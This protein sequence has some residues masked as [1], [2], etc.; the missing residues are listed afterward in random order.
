MEFS[1]RRFIMK[2]QN[3]HRIL[4][5]TL[6]L[7]MLC[8]MLSGL[9]LTAS[10]VEKYTITFSTPTNIGAPSAVEIDAGS[11]LRL[12][13]GIAAPEG[14]TFVGWYET[15]LPN[16][17]SLSDESGIKTGDYTPAGSM[18]LYACYKHAETISGYYE[19]SSAT[20]TAEPTKY[21]VVYEGT[22]K[23]IAFNASFSESGGGFNANGNHIPVSINNDQIAITDETEAAEYTVRR[24][25]LQNGVAICSILL[26]CNTYFGHT[27]SSAGMSVNAASIDNRITFD[28]VGLAEITDSNN[29]YMF[30][31]SENKYDR[32]SYYKITA[33]TKSNVYLY[34]KID[35]R[36][37]YTYTTFA[38]ACLH[39]NKTEVVITPATCTTA[40]TSMVV[41][42]DC[43]AVLISN[44]VLPA[45]GH[46]YGAFTSNNNST[47]S[48]TCSRCSDVVT[49]NCSFTSETVGNTTT[50]TCTVCGYS[51]Q[52]Q[53]GQTGCNHN[54]VN[55]ECTICHE[56]FRIRSATLSLNNQ[57]D[58]VYITEIP[59]GFTNVKLTVNGT[60]ITEYQ[61]INGLC[62]FFYTGVNPQCMGDNLSATLTGAY[63]GQTFTAT[64][65]SYSVRQY[66]VN[67]L[68]SSS[69][70]NE[71][72]ALVTALLVYGANAQYYA[73]YKTN[74]YVTSGSDIVNP[75]STAFTELSGYTAYFDGEPA[76]DTY[77]ISTGLTLTNG[78]AMNFRFYAE[79]VNDLTIYMTLNNKTKTYTANDFEAV[80]GEDH[81]YEI[82][83][84]GVHPNEFADNVTATFER[85]VDQVGNTL[86]YSV[87]AYIQAKQNDANKK[88]KGLVRALSVYGTC[89]EAYRNSLVS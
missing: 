11:P 59:T 71:L 77:W 85:D 1:I 15:P 73:G 2:S 57:I 46:A 50:Y 19:K 75:L 37:V 62:Y 88:L 3:L 31:Y 14:Y 32:F 53:T 89:V 74:A 6:A 56:L 52:E 18:T 13:S 83:Y 30:R 16:E 69:T 86:S 82:A 5:L 41:C 51:Y 35:P 81:V 43:G 25:S 76:S 39:Q 20:P 65:D 22:D 70:S 78:V 23:T 87:N 67:R 49:E 17:I 10:A 4:S 36:T 80:S 55:N 64:K 63:N 40:G 9:S 21:L 48:K 66:C 12:P 7:C 26:P 42:D 27:G 60:E 84:D 47:H 45:L 34:Q 61:E 38:Q 68:K 58:V 8:T 79:S 28:N 29:A 44:K 72:R 24:V 54:F 33:S